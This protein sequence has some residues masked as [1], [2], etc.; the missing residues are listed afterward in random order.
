MNV[1]SICKK[2][3]STKTSLVRHNKKV[4]CRFRKNHNCKYC[5]STFTTK[6]SM[7]RHINTQHPR[8][9]LEYNVLHGDNNNDCSNEEGNKAVKEDNVNVN[10]SND[11]AAPSQTI[12]NITNN[13]DNSINNNIN[14]NIVL[15]RYDAQDVEAALGNEEDITK[16]LGRSLSDV[17]TNL[18]KK[19]H[20]DYA[21][22][23]NLYV[24]NIN[25]SNILAYDGKIW[26]H[27][28]K[29]EI[30]E[31]LLRDNTYEA[32]QLMKKHSESLINYSRGNPYHKINII[33]KKLNDVDKIPNEKRKAKK[34]IHLM[35]VN[36]RDKVKKTY[37]KH[38]N[39]KI[40]TPK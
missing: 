40:K 39:K 22:N 25:G 4:D 16:L 12:N 2:T 30:L 10:K 15:N 37:E 14:V 8:S 5:Q 20:I 26:T 19:I 27:R 32:T 31:D 23:R 38:Y 21:P 11:N 18:V 24:S 17:I 28:D 33:N 1:C 9:E 7:M 34:E 3:Y 13:I 29:N 6:R 35:L 36:N